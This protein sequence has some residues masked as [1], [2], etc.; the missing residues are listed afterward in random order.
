MARV[1]LV[2]LGSAARTLWLPALRRRGLVPVAAVDPADE[3]RG[4][5]QT[6]HPGAAVYAD[7]HALFVA[8]P[9]W[10]VI[11]SPPDA[12]AAAVEA[13]LN[14][15]S[16]VLCEKPFVA[17]SGTARK[18]EALARRRGRHLAVNHEFAHMPVFAETLARLQGG[19]DGRLRFAQLWQNVDDAGVEGW[20]ADGRTLREFGTHAIDL[21]LRAFGRPPTKVTARMPAVAGRRGDPLDLVTLEWP[22]G[23]VGHLILNRLS[24]GDHRYLEARF[25]CEQASLRASIGGR[26]QLRL[27][28]SAR[29]RSPLLRLELAGGG[30]AWAELGERRETYARNGTDAL[31][32]ATATLLGQTLE[33][34]GRGAPLPCAASDALRVIQVIEAA[35][36]SA[37]TDRTVQL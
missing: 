26:A 7:L 15:G 9:D 37:R 17:D 32:H 18:L 11:T 19:R 33:A 25:D 14:A 34:A 23:G 36:R 12:H 35:E 29:S 20:R 21:L 2:G 30:A 28:L 5:F 13:A 27:G 3:A 31:V 1:A 6:T 10:V 22:G 8:P 16:H 24:P 4:W